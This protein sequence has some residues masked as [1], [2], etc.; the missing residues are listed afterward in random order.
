MLMTMRLK[1]M[2]HLWKEEVNTWMKYC[3]WIWEEKEEKEKKEKKEKEKEERKHSQLLRIHGNM[4]CGDVTSEIS[5]VLVKTLGI[6]KHSVKETRR[7]RVQVHCGVVF[8]FFSVVV[9]LV[10]SGCWVLFIV[11]TCGCGILWREV[12]GMIVCFILS[13]I[14]VL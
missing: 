9:V 8:I 3:S 13:V 14:V 12:F 10:L 7:G 6:F 11:L 5:V 4:G 1:K 2:V